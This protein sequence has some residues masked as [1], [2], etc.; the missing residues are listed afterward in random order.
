MPDNDILRKEPSNA[1]LSISSGKLYGTLTVPDGIKKMPVVL[2]ISG[3][4]P[5][6]RDCNNNMGLKTDAFKMMADSLKAAGIACLRYDKRGIGES[7]PAMTSEE[8]LRI[9]SFVSDAIAWIRFLKNDPRFGEVIVAGHSEGSLIG[10]LAA[11]KE[12]IAKF[13]SI[14]GS[15]AS[16]DQ[17]LG[18]QLDALAPETGKKGKIITDSLRKGY[19]AQSVPDDLLSIFRPSIQPYLKS[20][21]FLDPAA[22]LKKLKIPVLI[23]QGKNDLQVPETNATILKKA[24]PSAK[25]ELFENMNHCL[26]DTPADRSA[27]F[28]SYA[29]PKLPLTSTLSSKI[30]AFIK[31]K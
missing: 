15:G 2:L 29:N 23:V 25:M 14:A 4:G 26:K 10:I 1:E 6:D 27:N 18:E 30:V 21:L 31:S 20:E 24:M 7:A 17:T 28:A 19:I 5:T 12:K 8:N 13:I 16:L 9:D 3:S 11:Q 22:E